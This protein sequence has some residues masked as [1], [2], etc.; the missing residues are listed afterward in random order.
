MLYD[1]LFICYIT[2]VIIM[3]LYV[4]YN[5]LFIGNVQERRL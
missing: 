2:I 1:I 4:I 5:I 3:L